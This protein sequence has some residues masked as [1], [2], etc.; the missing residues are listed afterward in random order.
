M[1]E[2]NSSRRQS[3][4]LEGFDYSQPGIYFITICS[5]NSRCVFGSVDVT[6]V[7]LSK[8]G[9]IVQSCWFALPDWFSRIVIHESVVMPNHFHGLLDIQQQGHSLKSIV[10]SFKSAATRLSRQDG[11]LYGQ[12]LWHRGYYDHIVRSEKALTKIRQYILNNPV[13]WHLDK[14]NPESC[15]E[16]ATHGI[17]PEY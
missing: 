1:Y 5:K 2:F 12:E 6:E 11:H 8:L 13:N 15:P 9:S 17:V 3:L 4:R 14:L 7:R 10:G 16:K